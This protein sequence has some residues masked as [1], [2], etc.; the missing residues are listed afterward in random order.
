MLQGDSRSGNPVVVVP[1]GTSFGRR[2]RRFSLNQRSVEHGIE[3]A[4]ARKRQGAFK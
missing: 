2:V 4:M 1:P 3:F